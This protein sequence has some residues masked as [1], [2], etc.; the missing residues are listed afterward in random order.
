MSIIRELWQ[1]HSCGRYV[2]TEKNEDEKIFGHR[3]QN[4]APCCFV[5]CVRIPVYI[6]NK[7]KTERQL[8]F[9]FALAEGVKRKLNAPSPTLD[10][11]ELGEFNP[12]E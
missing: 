7:A 4:N 9:R 8:A 2:R 3:S 5:H 12:P 1:K 6:L 10:N 11:L